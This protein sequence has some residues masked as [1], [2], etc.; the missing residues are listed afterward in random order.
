MA[1]EGGDVVSI[2]AGQASPSTIPIISQLT[3]R[4][5][6][7]ESM[8]RKTYSRAEFHVKSNTGFSD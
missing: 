4:Q 5:Y 7:A 6:D 1:N 8:D 3:T 2:T